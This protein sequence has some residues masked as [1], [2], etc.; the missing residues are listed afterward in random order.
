MKDQMKEIMLKV[1]EMF[2]GADFVTIKV[3]GDRISALPSYE[4]NYSEKK[5]PTD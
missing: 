4:C 3:Y 5:C 1:N 2:P